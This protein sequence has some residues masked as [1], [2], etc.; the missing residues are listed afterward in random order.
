[1][2]DI[3]AGNQQSHQ[4]G[5]A[6]TISHVRYVLGEDRVTAF[7]SGLFV[8]I[9]AAALIG[10]FIVPYDPLASNTA[11]ALKP[12]SLSHWFGTDQLGRD[13]FSR[14]IVATRLDFVIAITSVCLLYTSPSPRDS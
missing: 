6:A 13:V 2:T 11:V 9:V 4:T 10:P 14:V 1:M 12:P 8:L 7:A 3:A 5:L